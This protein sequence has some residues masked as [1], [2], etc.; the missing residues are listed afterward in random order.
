M[1]WRCSSTKIR[2]KPLMGLR[3]LMGFAKGSV[4]SLL[5]GLA[6]GSYFLDERLRMASRGCRPSVQF[7]VNWVR[8]PVYLIGFSAQAISFCIDRSH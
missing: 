2:G 6:D 5:N 1:R 8:M 7:F 3:G 4:S